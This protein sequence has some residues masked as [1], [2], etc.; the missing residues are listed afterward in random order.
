MAELFVYS[1]SVG[2][3]PEHESIIFDRLDK[4]RVH[5]Q[6]VPVIGEE[7][8]IKGALFEVKRVIHCEYADEHFDA[9]VELVPSYK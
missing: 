2:E 7:I 5:L 4:G 6:R 9:S 1:D 3:E 8:R